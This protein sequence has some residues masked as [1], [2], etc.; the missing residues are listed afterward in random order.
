MGSQ[1]PGMVY[2]FRLRPDGTSHFPYSSEGIRQIYGVSPE[3]V[4]ED[5]AG[6][7]AALHPDDVPRVHA[8]IVSSAAHLTP[9]RDE[10]R[11]HLAD[12]RERWVLGKRG[13]RAGNRTAACFGTAS[14]RM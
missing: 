4:R 6:V 7:F 8:A 14:S 1:L 11:V 5:S 3:S 2:Q 13:A 12:G 9:W 10:Y